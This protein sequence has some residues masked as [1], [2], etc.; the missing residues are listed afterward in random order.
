[1]LCCI[2]S[3]LSLALCVVSLFF[4]AQVGHACFVA[5]HY[6]TRTGDT[7]SCIR[8]NALYAE[9]IAGEPSLC[10]WA[11]PIALDAMLL[12]CMAAYTLK[13][14]SLARYWLQQ[15]RAL[16]GRTW[17]DDFGLF[18]IAYQRTIENRRIPGLWDF[19]S[20][21]FHSGSG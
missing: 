19:V 7:A 3:V 17:A 12:C 4:T 16:F 9:H 21:S 5:G 6:A 8:Y 11:F 14:L 20:T 13:D 18:A 2:L 1:M 15:T 10:A